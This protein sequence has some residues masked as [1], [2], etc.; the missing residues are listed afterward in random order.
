M[1]AAGLV[2]PGSLARGGP[3]RH[4]GLPTRA[5]SRP[6]SRTPRPAP[7]D[8]AARAAPP[9]PATGPLAE[10]GGAW[11]W[12]PRPGGQTLPSQPP[13]NVRKYFSFYTLPSR[14]L[15]LGQGGRE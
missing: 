1:P 4:C 14:F 8:S 13:G 10:L 9:T 7:S 15:R 6:P 11:Q 2:A 12:P 3:C 5:R